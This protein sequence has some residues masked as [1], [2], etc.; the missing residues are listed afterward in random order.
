M[1]T[2]Y[3]TV[4]HVSPE[5]DLH[6][7]RA[8]GSHR[9]R[10]ACPQGTA[11]VYVA[12]KFNDAVQWAIS[13]VCHKKDDKHGAVR[14][15]RLRETCRGHHKKSGYY[16]D[17]T[18]YTVRVPKSVLTKSWFG[19]SWENEYFVTDIDSLEIVAKT[20]YD[21]HE[22]CQISKRHNGRRFEN[23]CKD[24]ISLAKH[25]PQNF[26]AK[27]YLRLR[28]EYDDQLLKRIQPKRT[29][30]KSI[31]RLLSKLIPFFAE[32]MY[33]RPKPIPH[34]ED[35]QKEKVLTLIEQIKSQLVSF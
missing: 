27:E 4:Y 13:Y 33:W 9:G 34:L 32:D 18:I 25:C 19:S 22:L 8:T 23:T 12:P 31:E 17:A 10:Q 7:L 20:T 6:K 5:G 28:S 21:F 29:E 3:T 16:Q 30:P 35:Q 1:A 24:Y 11:G 15:N 26:A 14:S 2:E